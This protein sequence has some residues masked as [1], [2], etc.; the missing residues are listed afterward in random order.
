MKPP[1]PRVHR[2]TTR[3]SLVPSRD[4]REPASAKLPLIRARMRTRLD[5]DNGHHFIYVSEMGR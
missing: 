2:S 3:Y 1:L 5:T 4:Q